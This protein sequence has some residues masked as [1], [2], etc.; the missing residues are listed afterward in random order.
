[1]IG[2]LFAEDDGTLR[3][4]QLT[5]IYVI[6]ADPGLLPELARTLGR[7]DLLS[8]SPVHHF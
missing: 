4:V 6:H 2:G 1:M 5:G 8:L 3:I 7:A